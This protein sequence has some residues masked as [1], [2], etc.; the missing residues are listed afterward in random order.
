MLVGSMTS[1]GLRRA[2]ECPAAQAD[3]ILEPGLVATVLADLGDEPGS[4]PLLSHALFA[5]WQRRRDR[6]LTIEDYQDAGGVRRAIGQ[7]AETVYAQ[8]DPAQQAVAKDVFL[9]LTALEG[10][11]GR[12]PPARAAG[13]AAR[14]PGRPG[15]GAGVGPTGRGAPG[16]P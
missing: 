8:L 14:R 15:R 5:T 7:T 9:R 12:Y 16:H 13:R 6:M 2:I 1:A 10:E 11:D 4:L 3:L